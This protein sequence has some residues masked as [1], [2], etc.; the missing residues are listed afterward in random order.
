MEEL[1]I[2]IDDSGKRSAEKV[3]K[4][5]KFLIEKLKALFDGFKIVLCG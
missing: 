2:D 4:A 1:K 5:K 3:A